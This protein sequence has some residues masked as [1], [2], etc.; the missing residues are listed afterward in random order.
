MYTTYTQKIPSLLIFALLLISHAINTPYKGNRKWM[1][2][3]TTKRGA[4]W[5]FFVGIIFKLRRNNCLAWDRNTPSIRLSDSRNFKRP[6]AKKCPRMSNFFRVPYLSWALL[7]GAF[8]PRY[9][10][11]C[12]IGAH[13]KN[14]HGKELM[15]E[16]NR[17]QQCRKRTDRL[18]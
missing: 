3:A 18:N 14:P 8:F 16:K 5:V 11:R 13:Q 2:S 17:H 15:S 6:F 9:P 7:I 4:R 1:R 10:N 12:K